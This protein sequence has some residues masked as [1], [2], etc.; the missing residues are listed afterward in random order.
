MVLLASISE[1]TELTLV[2]A[3][4]VD[5]GS[6]L[7]VR[8][9]LMVWG[10][11]VWTELAPVTLCPVAFPAGIWATLAVLVLLLPVSL[12]KLSLCLIAMILA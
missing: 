9:G 3:A 10:A 1:L 5:L 12:L 7:V 2:V 8:T 6:G 11:E 4:E